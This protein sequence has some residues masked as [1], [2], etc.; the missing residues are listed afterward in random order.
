KHLL[1]KAAERSHQATWK[2]IGSLLDNFPPAECAAYL[3][4]S[5]YAAS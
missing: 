1:R 5:G 4:N 2:R 3:T